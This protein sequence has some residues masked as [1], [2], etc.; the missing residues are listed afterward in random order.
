MSGGQYRDPASLGFLQ[1]KPLAFCIAVFRCNARHQENSRLRHFPAHQLFASSPVESYRL[2]DAELTGD[3]LQVAPQRP[4][5]HYGVTDAW[6][7][8]SDACQRADAV[9]EPF[10]L[11]QPANAQ[12]FEP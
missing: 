9:L 7:C 6:P 11:D 8:L 3:A 5:P 1:Y 2:P 10:F 4:I 12:Q